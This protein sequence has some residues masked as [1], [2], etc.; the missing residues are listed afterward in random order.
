MNIGVLTSSRADYGIYLPLLKEIE[1]DSFFNLKIIA[2]G[3]HLKVAYGYTVNHILNDGFDVKYKVNNLLNGD[4]P[5]DISLSYAN[6]VKLFG[7][8]WSKHKKEFD[9]VLCLGD[10]F[11]MAAAVNAGIPLN[12][13][14]G[15]L[16]SGETSEG[17]IDNIYRNQ[18][19][20][21]SKFHF[22]ALDHFASKVCQIVDRKNTTTI[23]GAIGLE[24]LKSLNLLNQMEFKKL[25]GIDLTIKTILLTIHPETIDFEKNESHCEQITSSIHELSEDYQI[26]ISLP[27]AD[28]NGSVYRNAFEKLSSIHKNV[29]TIENLGTKSYFSALKMCGIVVG[30]SSSGIIEAAT[31]GKYVINIG[32]RQKNR[33]CSDNTFHVKFDKVDIVKKIRDHIGKKYLGKNI[34]EKKN[35]V[36][37]IINKL[38][39][40]EL[41]SA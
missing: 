37:K 7:E 1:S 22:V 8:F 25:W 39:N 38:K 10:R 24:N 9:I 34:Y 4:S 29:L 26:L 2:F 12:I 23:T 6:T 13:T 16:H 17:S 30:N 31:F 5:R 3:T 32:N 15:H 11:E 21:A 19:T 35:G 36:K 28:T 14:Y 40:I 20:M 33:V 41:Y 27:N 18:I